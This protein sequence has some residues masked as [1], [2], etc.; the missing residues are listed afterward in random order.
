MK[1]I[2]KDLYVAIDKMQKYIGLNIPKSQYPKIRIN[3]KE[4]P[5]YI[6]SEN[7][8]ELS[9]ERD[10]FSGRT[11]GEE[12]GHFFRMKL[13]PGESDEILTD[14]FFGY[15]GARIF[16]EIAK[17]K[18][19]EKELFP[20]GEPFYIKDFLG[21]KKNVVG[22]LKDLRRRL[23]DKSKEYETE[24]E[25]ER[26]NKIRKE[27]LNL[28]EKRKDILHHFRGYEFAYRVNLKDVNLAELYKMPNKEVRKKYFRREKPGIEK[29]LAIASGLFL[30]ASIIIGGTSITGHTLS[31]SS[32]IQNLVGIL[33]FITSLILG[34]IYIKRKN[35]TLDS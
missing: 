33:F 30:V 34:Y 13:N 16:Y 12:I 7:V 8:I 9:S 23:K 32:N 28:V 17:K 15:L 25:D 29:R 27:G 14:E 26:R 22:R 18:K 19:I 3:E 1:E 5:S 20:F 6:C 4:E 11:I 10:I 35:R 21:D 2:E 31:I 24:R